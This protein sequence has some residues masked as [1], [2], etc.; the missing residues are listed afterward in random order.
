MDRTTE[1]TPTP[2]TIWDL[3]IHRGAKPADDGSM[4][5]GDFNDVGLDIM[6]GCCGCGAGLSAYNAYP[7]A[8][9]Y[10]RCGDCIGDL[11][12][13]TVEQ[14]ELEIIELTKDLED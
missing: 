2:I 8:S 14:A 3:A 4:T 1:L 7:S 11:G 12:W 6:G 10:W 5:G 13:P 9:G